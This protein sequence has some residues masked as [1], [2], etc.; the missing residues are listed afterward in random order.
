[1]QFCSAS[2]VGL[3]R[4]TNQDA[5][6]NTEICNALLAV[7]CDGMG[8]A[9]AGNIASTLACNEISSYVKRSYNSKMSVTAV[10]KML[11][12]AVKS[13]NNAV[14]SVA[15]G[16]ESL[17]GMGTTVVA[18]L[19][20]NNIAHIVHVGD[21]R[22]YITNEQSITQIT[23][24]HSIVQSHIES[25]DLTP[26]EAISHPNKNIITRAVGVEP[27]V[28]AEYNEVVLDNNI[29]VLCTDGLSGIVSP[30][31]VAQTALNNEFNSVPDELVK[32][33]N[34]LGGHDNITVT[35]IKN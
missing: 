18:A 2:H 32:L 14:F 19:I 7:V 3:V 34:K 27:D 11:R 20:R 10:E 8:G 1:M 13:A 22:A 9:N 17:K 12:S 31:S 26:E 15:Q 23:R 33:A 16:D 4:E 25:G 30:E 35:V 29:L 5:F 24:D 28:E 21:S 6:I